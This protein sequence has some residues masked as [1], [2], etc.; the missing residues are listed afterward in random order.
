DN[1]SNDPKVNDKTASSG[2]ELMNKAF[3]KS[4][5]ESGLNSIHK[6]A[7]P[8]GLKEGASVTGNDSA[9]AAQNSNNSH[10]NSSDYSNGEAGS[11]VT[12][13]KRSSSTSSGYSLPPT[14]SSSSSARQGKFSRPGSSNNYSRSSNSPESLES[15][16]ILAQTIAAKNTTNRDL[17][18]P[19]KNDSLF[20]VVS[21]AYIRNLEKVAGENA[22]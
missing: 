14:S 3:E 5:L 13:G 11:R 20:D 6:N 4:G 15:S 19:N 9:G 1:F 8:E 18:L 21:K 12:D 7:I 2:T 16:R 22:E 10:L 17:Y